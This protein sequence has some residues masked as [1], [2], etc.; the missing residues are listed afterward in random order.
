MTVL[1]IDRVYINRLASFGILRLNSAINLRNLALGKLEWNDR[2]KKIF[3]PL[4]VSV[5]CVE[6]HAKCEA[7]KNRS[8][9]P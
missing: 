7:M 1:L 4:A 9:I 8:E 3:L 5:T 6:I 2:K